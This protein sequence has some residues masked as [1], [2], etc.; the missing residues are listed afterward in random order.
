MVLSDYQMFPLRHQA[1]GTVPGLLDR[2]T[3]LDCSDKYVDLWTQGAI[4]CAAT[5]HSVFAIRVDHNA[6]AA[7]DVPQKPPRQLQSH[8]AAPVPLDSLGQ[9]HEPSPPTLRELVR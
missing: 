5:V 6:L 3:Y 2:P 4:Q 7:S 1:A 8:R 9:P